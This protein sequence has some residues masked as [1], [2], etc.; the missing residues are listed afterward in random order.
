MCNLFTACAGESTRYLLLP[1]LSTPS[2]AIISMPSTSHNDANNHT[3]TKSSKTDQ[4]R[5]S[6]CVCE[7]NEDDHYQNNAVHPSLRPFLTPPPKRK[8]IKP[9]EENN[10]VL[11][12]VHFM[13]TDNQYTP[14]IDN[15][16][17]SQNPHENQYLI[18]TSRGPD[19]TPVYNTISRTVATRGSSLPRTIRG[20]SRSLETVEDK[21]TLGMNHLKNNVEEVILV[22]TGAPQSQSPPTLNNSIHSKPQ[23]F[24]RFEEGNQSAAARLRADYISLEDLFSSCV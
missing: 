24:R 6:Q 13:L 17:P 1:A 20:C 16:N 8:F 3:F 10:E 11:E 19:M 22:P 5:Q 18:I 12:N 4:R 21:D 2:T 15:S 9:R 14:L 7:N 23:N